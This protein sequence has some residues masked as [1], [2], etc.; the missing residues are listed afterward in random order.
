MLEKGRLRKAELN[1]RNLIK[2]VATAERKATCF[3]A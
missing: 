1:G 2:N 3:I